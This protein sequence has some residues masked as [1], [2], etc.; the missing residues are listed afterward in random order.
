[1]WSEVSIRHEGSWTENALLGGSCYITSVVRRLR[2][3]I[4]HVSIVTTPF[5]ILD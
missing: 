4:G 3:G 5:Q 2:S 1:M